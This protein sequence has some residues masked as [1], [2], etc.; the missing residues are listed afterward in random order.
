MD[1]LLYIE[2]LRRLDKHLSIRSI[3]FYFFVS[4]SIRTSSHNLFVVIVSNFLSHTTAV[5]HISTQ[6]VRYIAFSLSNSLLA[7]SIPLSSS[8]A[9]SRDDALM[10]RRD[11]SGA[12]CSKCVNSCFTQT[13]IDPYLTADGHTFTEC[14]EIGGCTG[15]CARTDLPALG[16][17][18]YGTPCFNCVQSCFDQTGAF[19]FFTADGYSYQQCKLIGGCAESCDRD[20]IPAT[21]QLTGDACQACVTNC[22]NLT[23]TF[24]FYTPDGYTYAQCRS[25][26]GCSG[27]CS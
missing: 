1:Y 14:K 15:N 2:P 22:F 17:R 3:I 24:P 20:I 7:M 6:L 13:R 26:G 25:M 21:T 19:P 23:P 11:L 16:P 9:P 5:M 27:T 8:S 4:L 10:W 12:A 18:L